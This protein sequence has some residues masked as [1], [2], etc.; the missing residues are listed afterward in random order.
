MFGCF[1]VY[2]IISSVWFAVSLTKQVLPFG[3]TSY[4]SPAVNAAYCSQS[5]GF[6]SSCRDHWSSF[7]FS[8]RR[9]F[10]LGRVG[11]VDATCSPAIKSYFRE[12][13]SHSLPWFRRAIVALSNSVDCLQPRGYQCKLHTQTLFEL[14]L[15]AFD[16]EALE[17][18]GII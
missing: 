12:D 18:D 6:S 1:R 16:F 2:L 10:S 7:G 14:L 4:H 9:R 3:G 17:P 11:I 13:C 5:P 15:G 8:V